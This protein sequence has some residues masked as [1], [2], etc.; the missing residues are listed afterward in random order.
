M[1]KSNGKVKK[2]R[3][4]AGRSSNLKHKLPTRVKGPEVVMRWIEKKIEISNGLK[5]A[6]DQDN[7][8]C[9]KF[10]LQGENTNIEGYQ[11]LLQAKIYD[12]FGVSDINVASTLVT[13]CVNSMLSFSV[14]PL[15]SSNGEKL[16]AYLE[17]CFSDAISLFREFHP[18]DPFEAMMV[19]K[20][21]ILDLMSTR[22]FIAANSAGVMDH[23]TTYVTR[24]IKL[25]RLW[26]EIKEKLDKHRRP[27]Q[28][29]MVQHNHIHNEGQAIIGS[30]LSTGGGK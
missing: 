4:N 2:R 26:C 25:S 15:D 11:E 10:E 7:C 18:Q 6:F 3:V 14:D 13:N 20:L 8:Q 22:E 1:G 12:T 16:R 17:R 24:G 27:D 5:I 19:S 29:I 21:I 23:R 30:Q 28:R 9:V